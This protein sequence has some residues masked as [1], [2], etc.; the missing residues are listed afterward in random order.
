MSRSWVDIDLIA[1]A[2]NVATLSALAPGS[3][4][5][6]VVKANG[7]GHGAVEVA[8]A[9]LGAGATI[10]A[11]AQVAEG[12]ALRDAGIDAPVWVLSEPAPEEFDTAAANALEPTLCSPTGAMAAARVGGLAVH[13]MVDTGLGRVGAAP[14]EA[15]AIARQILSTG[16]LALASVWTHLACADDP[17]NP[18]TNQQLDCYEQMLTGFDA[19]HI[20]VVYRHA[21][22][23]AGVMAHPR[24]HYDVI[25]TGI[26]LY[27]LAP[28]DAL[29]DRVELQPALTWRSKVGFVKRVQAGTALSYGHRQ[30]VEVDTTVATVPVGYADGL[31]RGW[32][33]NGSVLIGGKR[34]PIVGV[35]TMD[36]TM[37]ACGNDG[38]SPGDEVV[39]IGSQ[40]DG[41]ISVEDMAADLGTINYEIPVLIGSRVERRFHQRG[42]DRSPPAVA[43]S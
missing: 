8:N 3:Q 26:A 37:V 6:A 30:Q 33:E 27:G 43:E 31:R 41:T 18:L 13:L 34:R 20:D 25:R 16:R 29:A 5:C 17:T 7:Y 19:A 21:A 9:A 42:L 24:S 12:V 39:L 1:V 35:V 36:Q 22:N 38:V 23:S 4:L 14:D 28:S 10:L 15:L 40:G 2:A 32:W 11:V